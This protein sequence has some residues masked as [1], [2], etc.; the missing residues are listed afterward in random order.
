MDI[1]VGE[2]T[3]AKP[4]KYDNDDARWDLD[5]LIKA[6]EILNDE[7][8]MPKI[9]AELKKRQEALDDT[10]KELNIEAKAKKGLNKLFG[11]K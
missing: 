1:K 11:K 3:V 7:S 9:K 4:E 5:T 6:N 2:I 8:K 10:A